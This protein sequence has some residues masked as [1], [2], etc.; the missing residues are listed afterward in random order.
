M[1]HPMN[2]IK[3]GDLICFNAAGMKRKSLGLVLDITVRNTNGYGEPLFNGDMWTAI[4]IR[5]I[6]KPPLMPTIDSWS[7]YHIEGIG[8]SCDNT[9]KLDTLWHKL[10]PSFEKIKVSA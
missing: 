3:V 1:I 10:H 6:E 8:W 2:K 9:T 7:L 4:K 5:W